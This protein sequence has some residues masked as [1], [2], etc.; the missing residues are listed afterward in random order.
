MHPSPLQDA[1]NYQKGE[2]TK[3]PVKHPCQKSLDHIP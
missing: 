1:E 3:I 2:K